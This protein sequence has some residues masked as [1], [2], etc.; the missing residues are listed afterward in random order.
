MPPRSP[1]YV[2]CRRTSFC[3]VGLGF[4]TVAKRGWGRHNFSFSASH[5]P[6]H[7]HRPWHSRGC[8]T[9][10]RPQGWRSWCHQEGR[11]SALGVTR[12]SVGRISAGAAP[13]SV[14]SPCDTDDALWKV[15]ELTRESREGSC[16]PAVL[17]ALPKAPP[18]DLR[19][20]SPA[21]TE[22]GECQREPVPPSCRVSSRGEHPVSIQEEI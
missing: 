10:K 1:V 19:A 12:A 14:R 8:R 6:R 11:D 20:S 5:P 4:L 18:L 22:I 3:D 9:W 17:R 7:P 2:D 16:W 15:R 21:V 13:G